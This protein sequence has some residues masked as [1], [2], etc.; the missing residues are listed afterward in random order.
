MQVIFLV[1]LDKN[2]L[3]GCSNTIPWHYAEDV[4]RFKRITTGYPIVMG[5]KTWES[6]PIHPLP[7]RINIVLTRSTS[8]NT[9]GKA[10]VFNNLKEVLTKFNTYDKIYV[11]GGAE[12]FNAYIQ[13][14]DILDVTKIDAE[15]SGDVYWHGVDSDAW[16]LQSSTVNGELDFRIYARKGKKYD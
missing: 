15:Y 4:K 8:Y 3:M 1:A 6:L 5:R 2:N 11:I 7:N 14:A 12:V 13:Y 16:E 9:D 10:E